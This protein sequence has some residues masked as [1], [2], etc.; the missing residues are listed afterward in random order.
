M[1]IFTGRV[2]GVSDGDTLT[3]LR[4]RTPVKVRLFGIDCPQMGQDFGS[5]AKQFTSELVFGKTVTV[6]PHDMDRYGRTVA[7]VLLPDGRFPRI[8]SY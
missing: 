8:A 7:D 2:V 1:P 3:V 4:E 6:V 5:R